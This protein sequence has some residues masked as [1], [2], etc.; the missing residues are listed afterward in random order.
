[1]L[2]GLANTRGPKWAEVFA[3]LR[4]RSADDPVAAAH[5]DLALGVFT[6][7]VTLL[8]ERFDLIDGFGELSADQWITEFDTITSA[9]RQ[10]VP[11]PDAAH[12][13]DAVTAHEH[14]L[15]KQ[16]ATFDVTP[17][18]HGGTILI[19]ATARWLW[20]DPLCDPLLTLNP[21][22]GNGFRDLAL[23][24]ARGQLRFIEEADFYEHGGRPW[25]PATGAS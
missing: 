1:L 4:A 12:E 8:C 13:P 16:L 19:L 5:Y 10:H 20:S 9:P 22:L 17:Y 23:R 15:S 3:A 24:C 18:E 2:R 14:L 21:I 6:E 25:S 7:A 11:P